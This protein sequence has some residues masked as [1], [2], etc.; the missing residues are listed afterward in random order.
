MAKFYS[1]S[2]LV[3]GAILVNH[4]QAQISLVISV[5]KEYNNTYSVVILDDTGPKSH[6]IFSNW[7]WRVLNVTET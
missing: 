3:P 6:L 1:S 5:C 4:Y 2:A 7:K